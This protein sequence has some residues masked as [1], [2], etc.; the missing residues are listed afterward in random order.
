MGRTGEVLDQARPAYIMCLAITTLLFLCVWQLPHCFFHVFGNYCIAF[1]CKVRNHRPF[2]S[3]IRS[4]R[5][6]VAMFPLPYN[7]V[8]KVPHAAKCGRHF[9]LSFQYK[10]YQRVPPTFCR[11]RYSGSGF[12]YPR[13]QAP[14][15]RNHRPQPSFVIPRMQAG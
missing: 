1:S 2:Y 15:V 14:Y 4:Y 8:L 11:V 10:M 12:I 13:M 7:N 5:Y 9:H 6:T 3:P